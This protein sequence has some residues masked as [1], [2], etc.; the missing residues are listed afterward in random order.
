MLNLGIAE[1]RAQALVVGRQLHQ[2]SCH[3]LLYTFIAF[4]EKKRYDAVLKADED[5]KFL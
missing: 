2:Q 3:L 1:D 5:D 4:Y